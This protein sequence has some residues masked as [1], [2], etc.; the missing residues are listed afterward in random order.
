MAATLQRDP[1]NGGI[2]N[3]IWLGFVTV[4]NKPT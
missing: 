3:Q 2:A 4:N 1:E